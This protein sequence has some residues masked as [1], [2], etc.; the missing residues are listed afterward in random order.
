MNESATRIDAIGESLYRISTMVPPDVVP[1]GFTFNQY[2]LVDDAP[3]L[4]HTGLRGQFDSVSKAVASVLPIERLRY[5]SFCHVEADE[6]GALNEFLDAAPRSEPLC[7]QVAAMTSIADLADRPPRVLADGESLTLGR[8]VVEWV[9]APHVPHG[10]ENGFLFEKTTRT[11]FCGDL[12]TQGGD[13]HEPLDDDIL[14]ASERM[15]A[16]MDYFAHGGNTRRVLE[17]LAS[18]EPR[19]LACMHGSAYQGDGGALLLALA[20]KLGA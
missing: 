15:R 10:W 7:S 17:R 4:F 16:G 3:L 1:G 9:D 18:L 20:D 14:E 2:L 12:F 5:I 13:E 19:T 8:H 6:C 11:L